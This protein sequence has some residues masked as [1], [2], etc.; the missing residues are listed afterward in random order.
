MQDR[1][2]CDATSFSICSIFLVI[3]LGQFS[4]AT[5]CNIQSSISI[6]LAL[7]LAISEWAAQ[8]WWTP[9]SFTRKFRNQIYS[10][11]L[12]NVLHIPADDC[13]PQSLPNEES[14]NEWNCISNFS[15]SQTEFQTQKQKN[16][17]NNQQVP[18]SYTALWSLR[19]ISDPHHQA[20]WGR[21]VHLR[22][23]LGP[24]QGLSLE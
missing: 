16:S 24:S 13:P 21:K 6:R 5:F 23:C 3:P 1:V 12:K 18:L 8:L 15:L 10:K 14:L 2:P 4:F 17:A 9:L 11:F 7:H 22:L 19:D 20:P